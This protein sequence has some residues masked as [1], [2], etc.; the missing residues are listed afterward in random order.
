MRGTRELWQLPCS[1]LVPCRCRCR[2]CRLSLTLYPIGLSAAV[3]PF[4]W[5]SVWCPTPETTADGTFGETHPTAAVSKAGSE[6]W[7]LGVVGMMEL[8]NRHTG[9][10]TVAGHAYGTYTD[11]AQ[12]ES[13]RAMLPA[14]LC[15]T[16]LAWS[17]IRH[18][19]H[20]NTTHTHTNCVTHTL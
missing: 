19:G 8:R 1:M 17:V 10:G 6:A 20:T 2:E 3:E 7:R 4:R 14:T 9:T 15:R 18:R 13:V 16:R 5:D 12:C 11:I